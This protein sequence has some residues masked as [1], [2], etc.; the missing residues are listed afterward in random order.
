MEV[1]TQPSLQL[2]PKHLKRLNASRIFLRVL[3]VA[4]IADATGKYI[5]PNIFRVRRHTDR[6]SAYCSP[7]Q[8]NPSPAAWSLWRKTLSSTI[9]HQT[10][11]RL[12]F[13]LRPWAHPPI[14]PQWQYHL[15]VLHH[16]LVEDIMAGGLFK[17]YRQGNTLCTFYTTYK[18]EF[19]CPPQLLLVTMITS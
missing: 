12:R 2:P 9:C 4:D 6:I 7:T 14:P 8:L 17:I 18:V 3:M 1:W 5:L 16:R 11:G 19:V 15:D 13:P 10:T